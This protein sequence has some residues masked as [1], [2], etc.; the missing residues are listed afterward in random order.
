[1]L[2]IGAN[3][4][5]RFAA[6]ARRHRHTPDY[7]A[8]IVGYPSH[9]DIAL[10]YLLTRRR[11]RPL[12]MDA[13]LGLYDTAIRDRGMIS[14]KHPLSVALW[15][16]EWLA[17]RLADIVLI[18]TPEQA[19]LLTRDYGLRPGRVI[20]VPTGVDED[21]WAPCP[22]PPASRPFRVVGWSTFIPLHG[23]NVIAAAE[24]LLAR[25]SVAVSL[26][27]MGDGQTASEFEQTLT[28]ARGEAPRDEPPI[29]WQREFVDPT[30]V[31]E[32]AQRAHCCLGIFGNT[33]KAGRVV[34]YKV[35]EALALGR[36]VITADTPATRRVLED[37]VSALLIPADSPQALAAAIERL[38]RDRVLCERLAIGGRQAFEKHLSR[39]AMSE[40]LSRLMQSLTERP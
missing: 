20:D 13:F 17:L 5:S 1:M 23:M 8:M 14:P 3:A 16:W 31:R 40:G 37:G 35:S 28:R 33:A 10:A 11:G 21:L 2:K 39:R 38:A 27:L 6:L 7:D 30:A 34:P 15:C 36:P 12:V 29:D 32:A 25:S 22:L 4:L 19:S 9:I 26:Q 18:D 24:P